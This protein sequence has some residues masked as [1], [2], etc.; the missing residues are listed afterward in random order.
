MNTRLLSIGV[1]A[2][3]FAAVVAVLTQR[4]Q[5]TT[6]RQEKDRIS[7]QVSQVE[8]QPKSSSR[9]ETVQSTAPPPEL[10][11]LRSQITQLTQRKNE[12]AAIRAENENLHSQLAARGTNSSTT[13][14]PGYIRRTQAQWVGMSTPENTV[15]SFL[16]A[17][18]NRDLTNLLRV[19]DTN[20]ATQLMRR[21]TNSPD[22]F[23]SLE[24]LPGMRIVNL[25]PQGDM[26]AWAD[27]QFA[28][29]DTVKEPIYFQL[30]NGEW[31]MNLP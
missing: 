22:F 10:L 24:S 25:R 21:M 17:V 14:P 12:L 7:T 6:L 30:Q 26:G 15:Q 16:W 19:L 27:L 29:D 31:K 8:D 18:Q 23:K 4:R 28:P 11:A 3:S 2:L 1:L 20:S 5:L 13:L 9:D